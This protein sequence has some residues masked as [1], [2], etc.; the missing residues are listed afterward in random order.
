MPS[1]LAGPAAAAQ[2]PRLVL[3]LSIDQLRADRVDEGL[4]GGLGRIAREGL[5]F[6]NAWLEHAITET[7]PGHASMVTGRH[8]SG[9]GIPGNNFIDGE[10]GRPTYCVED[11]GEDAVVFGAEHGRSPRHLR[12]T[13]LGDW[14]KRARP[15]TRVFSV[16]GKD[17][18]AIMLGGRS[19]DAAYWLVRSS[20]VGFT[21]SRYYVDERPPWVAAFNVAL[22][23]GL[24]QTWTHDVASGPAAE[25]TDD[26]PGESPEYGRTSG[27]PL[28][29]GDPERFA[30]NLYVTPYLDQV[31]LRFA[32]ELVTSEGL[33]RGAGPD[34]LAISLSATDRVGHLYGPYSHESRDTLVRLDRELG[35]FLDFL[36]AE[37]GGGS[38][39]VVLTSDHGVLPLPEWLAREGKLACPEEDGRVGL[40]MLVLGL[41]WELHKELGGVFSWPRQW[42]TIAGSRIGVRR[43]A[44]RRAGIPPENVLDVAESYLERVPAIARVWRVD[45]LQSETGE[46][47]RLYR[48]SFV[49][50]RSGDLLIQLER[51]CLISPSDY[52]T[53]HGTVYAYDR[54]VPLI[55]WGPGIET[56]RRHGRVA[57]VDIAPTLARSLGLEAPEDSDG[58]AHSVGEF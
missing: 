26:F 36:D 42:V 29:H 8:P 33:G 11:P 23:A 39:L 27:H 44:T 12:A 43:S 6:T 7:C 52:G 53:G 19:A 15:E 16:S 3:L 1:G 55:F 25:R 46:L 20:E 14:M 57:T 47:A 24:P 30:E 31:T 9:S 10:G 32:T 48:N 17:R 21:T 34:L 38:T 51:N 40:R 2:L 41:F 5:R 28:L 45:E 35:R 18:A 49:P 13:S 50:G 54:R 4:P 37:L 58:R 22:A 56:G